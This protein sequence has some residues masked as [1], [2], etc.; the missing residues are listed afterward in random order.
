MNELLWALLLGAAGL[1]WTEINEWL[2]WLA[3]KIMRKAVLI[4]SEELRERYS[5]EWAAVLDDVPGKIL[6]FVTACGFWW[7]ASRRRI[8]TAVMRRSNDAVFRVNDLGS[9]VAFFFFFGW[10]YACVAACVKLSSGGP[11]VY[12]IPSIGKDG[13]VFR[14]Y[15][16]RTMVNDSDAVLARHLRENEGARREWALHQRLENDPRF[17]RVGAFLRRYSLDELPIFINLLKGD[18]ALVGPSLCTPRSIVHYGDDFEQYLSVPPGI[19]GPWQI[20]GNDPSNWSERVRLDIEYTKN[21]SIWRDL[22]IIFKTPGAV[23]GKQGARR[24]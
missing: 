15:R 1:V 12:A 13:R 8:L 22:S 20:S 18:V 11:A 17:T 21:R 19:T 6:P 24:F 3:K 7:T 14:L 23:V 9:A 10:L 16:F 4:L 2:P 5:E